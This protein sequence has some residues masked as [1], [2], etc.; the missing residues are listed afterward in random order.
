MNFLYTW[1][2]NTETPAPT[3]S[4]TPTPEPPDIIYDD[5]N[6]TESKPGRTRIEKVIQDNDGTSN[7]TITVKMSNFT[8]IENDD[9]GAIH[10]KNCGLK[11]EGTVFTDCISGKGG[12]GAIYVQNSLS[13]LNTVNL[14]GLTFIRCSAEYGGGAYIYTSSESNLVE[15]EKCIFK[16]NVATKEDSPD[17][18]FGGSAVFLRAMWASVVR[19]KL[20]NNNIKI[21]QEFPSSANL[22]NNP[23]RESLLTLS[24]CHFEVDKN[25]KFS[26]FVHNDKS[27][28]QILLTGC[29]FSGKLQEGAYFIDGQSTNTNL[30]SFLANYQKFWTRMLSSLHLILRIKISSSFKL[31]SNQKKKMNKFKFMPILPSFFVAV[32]SALIVSIVIARKKRN[33]S[34][35]YSYVQKELNESS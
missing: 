25:M 35:D 10:I 21:F 5:S 2:P 31:M 24:H 15:I 30:A 12:G 14:K 34:K 6:Y 19:C 28:S 9:G 13:S 3:S 17:G 20:S 8:S 23:N 18:V 22:L 26:V 16:D 4:P 1:H 11:T 7:V 32:F 27:A 29:T 33:G